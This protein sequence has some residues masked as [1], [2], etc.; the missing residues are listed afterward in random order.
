MIQNFRNCEATYPLLN[1]LPLLSFKHTTAMY[2]LFD[3][4][5]PTLSSEN[6][7]QLSETDDITSSLSKR[8]DILTMYSG[9][10]CKCSKGP[11]QSAEAVSSTCLVLTRLFGSIVTWHNIQT[12]KEFHGVPSFLHLTVMDSVNSNSLSS[13]KLLQPAGLDWRGQFRTW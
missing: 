8:M 9:C 7:L 12:S 6:R 13:T 1:Q 11:M 10:F 4:I 2:Q 3:S 5:D